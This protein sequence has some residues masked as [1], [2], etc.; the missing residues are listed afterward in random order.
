MSRPF[1]LICAVMKDKVD[2]ARRALDSGVD[3]NVVDGPTRRSVLHFAAQNNALQSAALLLERKATVNHCSTEGTTPLII[4]YLQPHNEPPP[5]TMLSLLLDHGADVNASTKSG[6]TAI[7]W[8]AFQQWP[9]HVQILLEHKARTDIKAT[10]GDDQ[11][12]DALA[13]AKKYNRGYHH[14]IDT[15]R[16]AVIDMLSIAPPPAAPPAPMAS[17]APLS[18]GSSSTVSEH[19]SNANSNGNK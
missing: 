4:M 5:T 16:A 12:L 19:Q 18:S 8:A 2:D 7:M 14:V 17:C 15:D 3:P 11:G 9:K 13:I 10:S 6:E 1:D